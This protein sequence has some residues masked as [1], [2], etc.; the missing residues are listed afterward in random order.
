MEKYGRSGQATDDDII[1]CMRLACRIT[2]ATDT[3]SEYVILLLSYGN[4]GYTNSPPRYIIRTVP[5]MLQR[6][7]AQA[8]DCEG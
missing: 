1:R 5:V 2:K 4:N 6:K 7:M 3:D 8:L